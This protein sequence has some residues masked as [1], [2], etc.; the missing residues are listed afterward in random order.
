MGDTLAEVM[1]ASDAAESG[2]CVTDARPTSAVARTDGVQR[3][4]D[5]ARAAGTAWIL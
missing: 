5:V 1:N 2:G 3:V 4:R